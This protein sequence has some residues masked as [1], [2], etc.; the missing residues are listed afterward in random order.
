MISLSFSLP[1]ASSP[2]RATWDDAKSKDPA[3]LGETTLRY[4]FFGVSF[5][6]AT[7]DT[8]IFPEGRIVTLV[9]LALSLSFAVNRISS[10][11]NAA[12]GFTET[13]E[14][15]HLSQ[16]ENS[17]TVSSTKNPT[18]VSVSRQEF[19]DE[20]ARFVQAAYSRLTSEIPELSKNPVVQRLRLR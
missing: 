16:S 11:Q 15:I 4:K 5:R 1:D 19:V 6:L 2:W 14:V 20:T 18:V 12:F 7:R 17:L 3:S 8:E 13:D 9:D 10:G